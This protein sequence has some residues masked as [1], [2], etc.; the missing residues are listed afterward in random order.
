MIHDPAATRQGG[1]ASRR[2]TF[3]GAVVL[4]GILGVAVLI[5]LSTGDGTPSLYRAVAF[6]ATVC[7]AAALTGWLVS[8]WPCRSPATAVAASLAAVLVRLAVPLAALAWLQTGGVN[9]RAA[10]ADRLL[11]VFYLALLASDIVLNIMCG[12]KH[13][14]SR[15]ATRPN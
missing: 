1:I 13:V 14:G 10:G 12:E 8:R 4:L 7:G 6:T 3:S 15:D 9:L 11:A 5:T 2:T